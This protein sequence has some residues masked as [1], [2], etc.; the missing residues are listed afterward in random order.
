M[1]PYAS[2]GAPSR[3]P[4]IGFGIIAALTVVA[5]STLLPGLT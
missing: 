5:L 1:Q 3:S 2:L 4:L